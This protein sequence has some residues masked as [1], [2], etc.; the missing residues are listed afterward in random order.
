MKSLLLT[1]TAFSSLGL[2]QSELRELPLKSAGPSH[3]ELVSVQGVPELVI[4]SIEHSRGLSQIKYHLHGRECIA[5]TLRVRRLIWDAQRD[6]WA[7][8][9]QGE[10]LF[11]EKSM[12]LYPHE[13]GKYTQ[14]QELLQSRIA[15]YFHYYKEHIQPLL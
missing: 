9:A 11:T 8:D 5:I 7:R 14:A 6:D 2:A 1:L 12:V 15:D 13:K 3:A 10:L 4:E